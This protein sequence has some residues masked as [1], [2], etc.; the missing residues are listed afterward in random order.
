MKENSSLKKEIKNKEFQVGELI[1]IVREQTLALPKPKKSFFE[2]IGL[3]RK[4]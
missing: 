2:M 4:K 1:S 3:K